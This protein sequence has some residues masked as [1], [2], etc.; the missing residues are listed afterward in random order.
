MKDDCNGDAPPGLASRV[1]VSIAV[2]FG[3]LVFLV[4]W[5]FFFAG[6][7]SVLENIGIALVAFLVGIAILAVVWASWGIKYGKKAER[8]G[9]EWDKKAPPRRRRKR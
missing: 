9:K 8:W 7:F 2:V 4:V 3:W 5:L 1:A 6:G